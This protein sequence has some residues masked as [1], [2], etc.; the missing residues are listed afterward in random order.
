MSTLGLWPVSVS[1][2]SEGGEGA[3]AFHNRLAEAGAVRDNFIKGEGHGLQEP[4]VQ[5]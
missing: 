4:Q 3:F 5:C 1:A 2:T